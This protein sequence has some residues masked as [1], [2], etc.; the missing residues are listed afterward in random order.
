MS[1]SNGRRLRCRGSCCEKSSA[2][3]MG[4]G[5]LLCR[6]DGGPSR[7]ILLARQGRCVRRRSKCALTAPPQ[8]PSQRPSLCEMV[9]GPG[10]SSPIQ[11]DRE[12]TT[13]D[14]DGSGPNSRSD[15]HC[16]TFVG[17]REEP[18]GESRFSSF[19]IAAVVA[20]LCFE[21]IAAP[22]TAV[23]RDLPEADALP[24]HGRSNI[25]ACNLED[26]FAKLF[27]NTTVTLRL[28]GTAMRADA[29]KR[30]GASG[31]SAGSMAG[32]AAVGSLWSSLPRPIFPQQQDQNSAPV[33]IPTS[34]A[35]MPVRMAGCA[36]VRATPN[37]PAPS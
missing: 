4:R 7:C 27:E 3:S 12:R 15:A 26:S 31:P 13:A 32:E 30:R 37:R 6:H 8:R 16:A 18:S 9:A 24:L 29:G 1:L 17:D 21:Y 20:T 10:F 5:R 34:P 19:G 14:C 2:S 25:S 22:Q 11:P 33:T 36:A 28:V 35:K 23:G